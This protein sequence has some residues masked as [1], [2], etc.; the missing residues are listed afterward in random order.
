MNKVSTSLTVFLGSALLV[1]TGCLGAPENLP[2]QNRPSAVLLI[3]VDGLGSQRL[4][5][6]GGNVSAPALESLAADGVVWNDAW[7]VTPITRP[8]V[9]TYLTGMAPDR[10]GI[11]DDLFTFLD[12]DTP[13]LA[14][15]LAEQGY[16]TAAFPDSSFLGFSS[17]LLRGFEVV[18]DPPNIPLGPARWFPV[19]RPAEQTT[20]D[21][22]AWLGAL[23]EETPYFAWLHFTQPL[24]GQWFPQKVPAQTLKPRVKAKGERAEGKPASP[25]ELTEPP[26]AEELA[27]AEQAGMIEFD[28]ALRRVLDV[29]RI[30]G[31]FD[32][33]L[34]VVAGTQ[35]NPRG[36]ESD[37]VGPGFSLGPQAVEVPVVVHLPAGT[38]PDLDADRMVWAPDIPATIADLTQIELAP[39]AEGLS[40]LRPEADDRIIFAWS[41][42]PLDQMLWPALRAARTG[43]EVFHEGAG[44][45]S[46]GA[47]RFAVA[48]AAREE[49]PAPAVTLES[50]RPLLAAL[51]I[52]VDPLPLAG[53]DS[54]SA[55]DRR[56]ASEVLWNAR[57]VMRQGGTGMALRMYGEISNH[58]PMNLAAWLDRGQILSVAKPE[59]GRRILGRALVRY[60][61]NLELLHWYAHAIWG[62]S[63]ESAEG[64][65]EVILPFKPQEADVLYDLACTRS[66][67]DDFDAS[68]DYLRRAIE[69]GYRNWQHMESDPDLRKLRESG[70]F[71][72]LLREY[73]R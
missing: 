21:F 63:N 27:A 43:A 9:A 26:S 56:R 59:R 55:E 28:D 20:T 66:L 25:A 73:R 18:D 46:A 16:R 49:P 29:L 51:D 71:S 50:I 36:G 23:P 57:A 14:A 61:T 40:L 69:A 7:T 65:L 54:F 15:R 8:A 64:L 34:V 60:P 47:E 2:P 33:A 39:D 1:L 44:G 11:R 62:E 42:A 70:R 72:E 68:E 32:T 35:G 10:H 48:L 58:D 6:F 53:R 24:N 19:T 45:E 30:R 38:C 41:W 5:L 3:T 12:A 4:A 31:E 22:E 17:G 13:T 67:A 37:P 52:E